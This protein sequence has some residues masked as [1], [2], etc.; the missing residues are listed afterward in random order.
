MR[1]HKFAFLIEKPE[2][3]AIIIHDMG[4]KTHD[5]SIPITTEAQAYALCK[6]I[7]VFGFWRRKDRDLR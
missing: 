1:G 6:Q 4:S 3:E 2:C 7:G 5:F